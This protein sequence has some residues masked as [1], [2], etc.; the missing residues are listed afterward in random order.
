MI[1]KYNRYYL[2]LTMLVDGVEKVFK[3]PYMTCPEG[4]QLKKI[5]KYIKWVYGRDKEGNPAKN[6]E[7]VSVDVEDRID[8]IEED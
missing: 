1:S 4:E 3:H 5:M 6:F 7:W 8:E 2:T